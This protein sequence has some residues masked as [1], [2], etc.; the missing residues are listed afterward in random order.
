MGDACGFE[1][2]QEDPRP[3]KRY[4]GARHEPKVFVVYV[5]DAESKGDATFVPVM[6]ATLKGPDVV[7]ALLR[8][9]LQRLE[10]TKADQVFFIGD[11]APWIWKR[12]PYSYKPS[13]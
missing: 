10:I 13:A 11:G 3:K 1:K 5:V 7:F 8:S 2:M 12:V 9:Y 4:T 6:D